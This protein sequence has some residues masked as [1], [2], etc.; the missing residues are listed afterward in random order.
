MLLGP[1]AVSDLLILA[2]GDRET[3]PWN[4]GFPLWDSFQRAYGTSNLSN[5]ANTPIRNHQ[6]IF[7]QEGSERASKLRQS[8]RR[9]RIQERP[10][11][12]GMGQGLQFVPLHP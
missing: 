1:Q 2:R 5:M 3:P 4:S 9:G 11:S 12:V 6:L 7:S 8:N 10:G